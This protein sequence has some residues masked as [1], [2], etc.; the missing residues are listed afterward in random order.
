MIWRYIWWRVKK[1]CNISLNIFE[2]IET[3]C[4]VF[5]WHKVSHSCP[6]QVLGNS[7]AVGEKSDLFIHQQYDYTGKI[8]DKNG[9]SLKTGFNV[10]VLLLQVQQLIME[11]IWNRLHPQYLVVI[12]MTCWKTFSVIQIKKLRDWLKAMSCFFLKIMFNFLSWRPFPR[13]ST[14]CFV[15]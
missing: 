10:L 5:W 1:V 7:W 4:Y 14:C 6:N 8:Y 12:H 13:D 3:N 11:V 15:L 2:V 9:L